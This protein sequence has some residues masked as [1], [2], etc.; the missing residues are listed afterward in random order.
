MAAPLQAIPLMATV[1]SISRFHS[2][3]LARQLENRQALA[4]IYTGLA[5][6]FVRRYAVRDDR[7]RSFP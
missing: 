7:L 4:A 1:A 2:F 3:E 6:R 5:R